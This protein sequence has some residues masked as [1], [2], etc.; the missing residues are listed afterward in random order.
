M[1][2]RQ[3]KQ[4][5]YLHSEVSRLYPSEEDLSNSLSFTNEN[6]PKKHVIGHVIVL[7]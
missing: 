7:K 1:V 4:Y 5:N 3:L 6:P 2:T